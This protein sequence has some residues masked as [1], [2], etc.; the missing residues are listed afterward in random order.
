[1]HCNSQIQKFTKFTVQLIQLSTV[2]N[3]THSY[4]KK[5]TTKHHSQFWVLSISKR[6]T[7]RMSVQL[8]LLV[9]WLVLLRD[10]N[11]FVGWDDRRWS[12][13]LQFLL[14]QLVIHPSSCGLFPCLHLFF[15]RIWMNLA[16]SLSRKI[17][18]AGTRQVLIFWMTIGEQSHTG[19][20]IHVWSHLEAWHCNGMPCW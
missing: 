9:G 2:Y 20:D 18:M 3:T 6:S 13:S 16:R 7:S 14:S 19:S 10:H 5:R 12:M 17:L 4:S 1:M 8:M 15:S 11:K